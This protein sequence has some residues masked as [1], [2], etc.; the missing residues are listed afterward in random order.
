MDLIDKQNST[1]VEHHEAVIGFLDLATQVLDRTRHRRN[2]DELTLRVCGDDVGQGGFTRTGR[3]IEDHA[4]KHVMFDGAAQ[5]R[6]RPHRL[7]LTHVIVKRVGTHAHR[8]G[9]V[10]ELF[11]PL[12]AAEKGIHESVPSIRH[13]M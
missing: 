3:S 2:L 10:L 6:T 4:R 8:Q 5:P 7:P 1:A 11:A 13:R 9:C 12:G